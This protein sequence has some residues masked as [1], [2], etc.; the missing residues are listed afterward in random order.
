LGFLK[1]NLLKVQQL[2]WILAALAFFLPNQN[3][4]ADAWDYAAAL[5]HQF[6]LFETHH[7]LHNLPAWLVQQVLVSASIKVEPIALMC[8]LNALYGVFVLQVLVTIFKRRGFSDS[9]IIPLVLLA[10]ASWGMLRFMS[11]NE[12]YILP[13]LFSLLGVNALEKSKLNNSPLYQAGFWFAFACLFHQ[14]QVWWWLA[15][16][17]TL[18]VASP[19]YVVSYLLPALVVPVT[20]LLVHFLVWE[21]PATAQAL[22]ES[23]FHVLVEGNLATVNFGNTFLLWLI[24]IGRSF[25]Q[26]HGY[27]AILPGLDLKWYLAFTLLPLALLYLVWQFWVTKKNARFTPIKLGWILPLLLLAFCF[28]SGGNAEFLVGLPIALLLWLQP[29][30]EGN[31]LRNIGL[32]ILAWN[33]SL[34]LAPLNRYEFQ[35]FQQEAKF[36]SENPDALYISDYS[37]EINAILIYQS[38]LNTYLSRPGKDGVPS[39]STLENDISTAFKQGKRVFT[40][41]LNKLPL[42]RAGLLANS[43]EW[44]KAYRLQSRTTLVFSGQTW[45]VWELLPRN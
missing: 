26:M 31:L 32:W 3:H 44:W 8:L 13:I 7:L 43:N 37:T 20:Y 42:S 16:L 21:K 5:K 36:I 4:S 22:G 18:L 39:D 9:Q 11:E 19:K 24:G 6:D 33:V 17:I 35:P 41:S 10:G 12:T 27:F 30:L 1:K 28:Y 25:I 45:T 2:I 23:F 14:L 15:G 34:G 38:G 40:S 29:T